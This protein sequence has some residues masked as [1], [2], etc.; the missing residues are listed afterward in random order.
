MATYTTVT[1]GRADNIELNLT[2]EKKESLTVTPPPQF[3]GV[4]DKWSPEDLF[5]ASISSCYILTFKSFAQFQKLA[6]TNIEVKADA[7]LE[8]V[9]KGFAFTKVDIYVNLE[10]CCEGNV[11]PYLELLYKAKDNCLVTK[12]MNCEFSLHP[13]IKNTAKK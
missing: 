5:S 10:I 12:S 6:W 1:T 2:A 4:E 11:D 9:E 8:K 13:K 7:H 3:Q